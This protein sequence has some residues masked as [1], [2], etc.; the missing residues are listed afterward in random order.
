M[1]GSISSNVGTIK[2]QRKYAYFEW[3]V[4]LR[5]GYILDMLTFS[6]RDETKRTTVKSAEVY[7]HQMLGDVFNILMSTVQRLFV[8]LRYC[9]NNRFN[10][11]RRCARYM[12]GLELI[13][14]AYKDIRSDIEI[15]VQTILSLVCNSSR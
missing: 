5:L 4:E 11:L 13:Y 9:D 12:G 8:S 2:N 6:H 1:D 14:V 10:C 7:Q 3:V 15:E